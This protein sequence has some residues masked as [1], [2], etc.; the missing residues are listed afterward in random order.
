MDGIMP[1]DA[2]SGFSN[3]IKAAIGGMELEEQRHDEVMK[4]IDWKIRERKI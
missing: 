2:E 3:A 1:K 4:F